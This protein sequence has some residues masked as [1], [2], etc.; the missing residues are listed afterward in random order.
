MNYKIC[1]GLLLGFAVFGTFVNGSEISKSSDVELTNIR[2]RE[3]KGHFTEVQILLKNNTETPK[4]FILLSPGETLNDNTVFFDWKNEDVAFYLWRY[5]HDNKYFKMLTNRKLGGGFSAF[6][7]KPQSKIILNNY[8]Y[9]CFDE[10]NFIEVFESKTF[11]INGKQAIEELVP[12]ENFA[13]S[14]IS[15]SIPMFNGV[16]F[17]DGT[18]EKEETKLL[19]KDNIKIKSITLVDAKKYYFPIE[20]VKP[21]QTAPTVTN[22]KYKNIEGLGG[23]KREHTPSQ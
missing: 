14:D 23:G 19:F 12:V 13:N 9:Y 6:L 4:W 10:C 22:N 8:T 2:R 17:S 15:L 16:G 11:L 20:K 21:R 18:I 7:L 3:G 1:I 5:L